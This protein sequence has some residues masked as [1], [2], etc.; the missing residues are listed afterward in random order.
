[1]PKN[2]K[3]RRAFTDGVSA[4][5][6]LLLIGQFAFA[7]D[8]TPALSTRNSANITNATSDP[9]PSS[10]TDSTTDSTTSSTTSSMTSSTASKMT[11]TTSESPAENSTSVATPSPNSIESAA[12][13]S[14]APDAGRSKLELPAI[15]SDKKFAP[16]N[17][18][19]DLKM[20]ADAGSLSRY[21]VKGT[22]DYSG[23][24]VNDFSNPD[25][26]NPDH[27][28]GAHK[29]N[30]RGSLAT[31][32]RFDSDQAMSFGT[33][34]TVQTPT[35]GINRVDVNNPYLSYDLTKKL[36]KFQTRISP[37]ATLITTPESRNVGQ[38]A[39]GGLTG[40][41]VYNLG[42]SRW[43]VNVDGN[44]SYGFFNRRYRYPV[45]RRTSALDVGLYPGIKY[46]A[47]DNL[48]I[49][50]SLSFGYLTPRV[51]QKL[52]A[53]NPKTV[54]A[55]IGVGWAI[56]RDIYIYPYLTLYPTQLEEESTSFNVSTVFSIL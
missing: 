10:T 55:R 8:S 14:E 21:S 23:P 17:A 20:R 22:L 44:A 39:T 45:D 29:T 6:V 15:L 33:G 3:P 53:L 31:R 7:Q 16:D 28:I 38:V 32:Y 12:S 50:A 54:G 30:A 52:S 19:T 27:T 40:G 26:P 24:T 42:Y 49:A 13:S 25:Q 36:G 9:A 46:N 34:I 43:A 51:E 37:T 2:A 5:G 41:A 56:K 4:I 48:T 47:T 1:M 11:S 35:Y 18:I